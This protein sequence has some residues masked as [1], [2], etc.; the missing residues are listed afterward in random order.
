MVQTGGQLAY[1]ILLSVFPFLIYVNALIGAFRFTALE[2]REVLTPIF[3]ENVVSMLTAY[4]ENISETGSMSLLSFGIIV[5]LFSA[6]RSVRALSSVMDTA[7]GVQKTRGF[8]WNL[9]FSILF[10][11]CLGLAF[12][13]F[14]I[15]VPLSEHFLMS[16]TDLFGFSDRVAMY[17]NT[18]RWAVTVAVLFFVLVLLYYVVP[19]RRMRLRYVCPGAV[20]G[21][22]GFLF[23]TRGFSVYVTYFIKNSAI[24]GSISAVI[25]LLLW[26]YCV[27]VILAVGAEL[28]GILEGR[29]LKARRGSRSDG[30]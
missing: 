9:G 1:F 22:V 28:N 14:S 4:I 25:L 19:N 30:R 23:L 11:F 12:A 6:S 29:S 15:V 20:L 17:L 7:Y 27:G 24:Y 18:W 5:T 16:L 8:W 2:I 26:L 10:I 21:V 13:A 3:P